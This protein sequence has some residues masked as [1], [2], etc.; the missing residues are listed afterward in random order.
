MPL[1]GVHFPSKRLLKRAREYQLGK[2]ILSDDCGIDAGWGELCQRFVGYSPHDQELPLARMV[3]YPLS[4]FLAEIPEESSLSRARREP[5]Q[6]DEQIG[7][8]FSQK[9]LLH[10][11]L[12]S[13]E[14]QVS[15]FHAS[16]G[17]SS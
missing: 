5:I 9:T 6:R 13:S 11:I 10:K 4:Q 1:R 17:E 16:F 12:M 2:F 15:L 3:A 7:G 8:E 14:Q